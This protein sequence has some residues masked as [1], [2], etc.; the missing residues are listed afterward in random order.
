M[1]YESTST[2]AIITV[3]FT[4]LIHTEPNNTSHDSYNEWDITV[5]NIHWRAT[6]SVTQVLWPLHHVEVFY[7]YMHFNLHSMQIGKGSSEKT[8]DPWHSFILKQIQKLNNKN[9]ECKANAKIGEQ[10]Q[11]NNCVHRLSVGVWFV[12]K[13]SICIMS[14]YNNNNF[15]NRIII[16]V[17]AVNTTHILI[18]P[19]QIWK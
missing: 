10:K 4:G 18:R 8:Q 1:N 19:H 17:N 14:Y 6:Q 2:Y 7:Q 9:N 3:R 12:S 16:S 11:Y 13:T 15:L 5:W